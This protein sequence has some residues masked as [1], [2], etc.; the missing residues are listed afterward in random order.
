LCLVNTIVFVLTILKF[1]LYV[2]IVISI[3]F[4]KR[5]K[6]SAFRALAFDALQHQKS[7][8]QSSC[9]VMQTKARHKTDTVKTN[10]IMAENNLSKTMSDDVNTE[11]QGIYNELLPDLKEK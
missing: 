8:L 7:K 10:S 6:Q 3:L 11:K 4:L 9:D 2:P 1:T 5:N